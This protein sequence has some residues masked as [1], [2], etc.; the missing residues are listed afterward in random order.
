MSYKNFEKAIKLIEQNK[1]LCED[2]APQSENAIVNAET[3]LSVSFPK[4][5]KKFLKLI[6]S[7]SLGPIDIFGLTFNDYSKYMP[8]DVVCETLKKRKISI[9]PAFPRNFVPVYDLGDGEIFCFDT[10]QM[11]VKGECP[12]VAWYFGRI[13]HLYEDFGDFLLEKVLLGLES[14]EEDG[15]KVNK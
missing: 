14:L 13:E 12:L 9:S 5:Y 10:E 11:N 4:S 15:K 3:A 6:G 7:L 1:D 8:N 2:I